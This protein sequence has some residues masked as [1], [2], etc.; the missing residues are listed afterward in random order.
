MANSV[1]RC[2]NIKKTTNSLGHTTY[3]K[4]THT[5]KYLDAQ[6]HHHP[7]Q[8]SGVVKTLAHRT[9]QICD[10]DNIKKEKDN[11]V[12]IFKSNGYKEKHMRKLIYQNR[13][14]SKIEAPE[15]EN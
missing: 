4:P 7:S 2:F 14:S 1:F 3:R 5:N 15:S 8:I 9:E 10:S 6:S 12:N 13:T 11:L